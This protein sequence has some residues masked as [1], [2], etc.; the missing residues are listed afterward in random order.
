V[1]KAVFILAATLSAGGFPAAAQAAAGLSVSTAFQYVKGAYTNDPDTNVFA[2]NNGVRYQ[3]PRWNIGLNVPLLLTQSGDSSGTSG[4]S[5]GMS[6]GLGDVSLNSWIEILGEDGLLP[7]V[8]GTAQWKLP[9]AS[10]SFGTGK[11]DY[12]VGI[13]IRK[14]FRPFVLFGDVGYQNIGDPEGT[15]YNDP[16]AYGAGLGV[17]LGSGRSS[18]LFYYQDGG[19]VLDA[20]P[21]SRQASLGL[22][23]QISSQTILS[24]IALRGFTSSAPDLGVSTGIQYSL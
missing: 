17:F 1:R 18:L 22:N 23:Y 15:T 16:I 2:W 12:G 19:R 20:F 21:A 5:S 13:G 9:T 14:N 4:M 8:L 10:T 24:L 3:T 6:A 11:S 7:T